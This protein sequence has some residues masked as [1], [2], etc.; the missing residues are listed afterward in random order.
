MTY[1]ISCPYTPFLVLPFSYTLS[2]TPF[3]VL[4]FS[5]IFP[6]A[7]YTEGSDYAV[8]A[9]EYGYHLGMAYQIVDDILDFTGTTHTITYLSYHLSLIHYFIH[10]HINTSTSLTDD[11]L[12]FT[13][14]THLS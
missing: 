4:S 13:C 1:L 6:T 14:T 3:L 2:P 9:E 8:A 11:I 7:G 10:S 12:D 5:S